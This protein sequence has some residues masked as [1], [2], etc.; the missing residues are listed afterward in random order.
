MFRKDAVKMQQQVRVGREWGAWNEVSL[1][2]HQ[3]QVC[4]H[5][6]PEL[7]F[8]ESPARERH[9]VLRAG[10]GGGRKETTAGFTGVSWLSSS[11]FSGVKEFPA[12][13]W[14]RHPRTGRRSQKSRGSH[15]EE[16]SPPSA[17]RRDLSD[18]LLPP[19]SLSSPLPYTIDASIRELLQTQQTSEYNK[20]EADSQI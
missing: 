13:E 16:P 4:S 6:L 8:W 1:H 17:P 19:F 20:G 7:F 18:S 5:F 14:V 11:C 3:G 9:P 15:P 12:I 10:A 2:P